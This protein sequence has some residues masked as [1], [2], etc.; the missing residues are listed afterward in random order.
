MVR[1]FS[2]KYAMLFFWTLLYFVHILDGCGSQ[3]TDSVVATANWW[4]RLSVLYTVYFILTQ[5]YRMPLEHWE[6]NTWVTSTHFMIDLWCLW[7]VFETW[8]LQPPSIILLL[9]FHWGRKVIWV[10]NDMVSKLPFIFVLLQN[11]RTHFLSFYLLLT[12]N[13]F[14]YF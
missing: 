8:K 12:L 2:R 11:D 10:S 14:S 5:S 9:V 3:F 7:V 6:Y 1:C 13:G 4:R